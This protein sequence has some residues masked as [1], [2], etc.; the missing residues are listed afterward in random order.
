[1]FSA[2]YLENYLSIYHGAFIFYMLIGLVENMT[3]ID[4]GFSRS[5]VKVTSILL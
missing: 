2:H 4:F 1:M 3:G 5:K